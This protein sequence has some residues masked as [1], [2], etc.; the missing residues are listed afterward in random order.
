[1]F[2]MNINTFSQSYHV[3][4]RWSIWVFNWWCGNEVISCFLV[5]PDFISSI[6]LRSVSFGEMCYR[7]CF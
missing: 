4:N 3:C 6:R 1:M 2:N 7:I 5:L